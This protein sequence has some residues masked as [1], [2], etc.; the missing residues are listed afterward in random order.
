MVICTELK[1]YYDDPLNNYA[2]QLLAKLSI[3]LEQKN[4]QEL[5]YDEIFNR[6]KRVPKKK[7]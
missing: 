7:F 3:V 4:K 1:Q 6:E 2:K 5:N